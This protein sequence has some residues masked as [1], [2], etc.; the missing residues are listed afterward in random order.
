M[1]FPNLKAPAHMARAFL[2]TDTVFDILLDTGAS[3]H[4]SSCIDNFV[5][6]KDG[7]IPI[8]NSHREIKGLSGNCKAFGFGTIRWE[9]PNSTGTY[10]TTKGPE[11][12]VPSANIRLFSPR[13]LFSTHKSGRLIMDHESFRLQLP[14][15]GELI[16]G[17]FESNLP[18]AKEKLI[19]RWR[20][21]KCQFTP[22]FQHKW[23][24]AIRITEDYR[25]PP[26]PT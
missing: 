1:L 2:S 5:G 9:V 25:C 13:T 3:V 10:R 12:Y 7:L 6:G 19:P 26:I 17:N 16:L 24:P 20:V 11:Y 22:A 8:R 21:L 18:F 23:R 15:G 14:Q 4:I